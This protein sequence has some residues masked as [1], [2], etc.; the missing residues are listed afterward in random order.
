MRKLVLIIAI[1]L[2][3][4]SFSQ[5]DSVS[6]GAGYIHQAFYSFSNGIVKTSTSDWELAFGIGGFNIDIRTNEGHSVKLYL[7]PNG[8][9][10]DWNN[11]DTT[12][13][14]NWTPRHNDENDW[15]NTAFTTGGNHPDYGWGVY[16]STT[17]NVVGDSIYIMQTKAGNFKKLRI[18]GMYA[19]TAEFV[20]T[21]ADLDGSNQMTGK[22]KKTD[23]TGKNFAYYSVDN[24]TVLDLEPMAADWD[25]VFNKYGAVHPTGGYYN[26]TGIQTN[27]NR[28]S[29]EARGVDLNTVD[30]NTQ[31]FVDEIG[32][33][34]WDWKSF[35][36]GTFSYDIE[37]SLTYFVADTNNNVWQITMT[38]FD[39][40]VGKF[41]FNKKRVSGVSVE[42]INS[43]FNEVKL[44]PNP[45]TQNVT[46]SID[47]EQAQNNVELNIYSLTGQRVWSQ[48]INIV[49]QVNVNIPVSEWQKGIYIVRIGNNNAVVKQLIVQ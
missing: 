13:L 39:Y 11:I 6:I 37:D 43:G 8:D 7:Y 47:S 48:R 4:I 16:N 28:T 23:Y 18:D 30:W 14:Q 38:G 34:G 46:I 20:F 33:I 31:N 35:N 41:V 17:H 24:N 1:C 25:I 15:S 9:T 42:D 19:M 3:L 21:Y 5:A 22:V 10:A 27:K 26:V 12:G 2:P 49:D 44:Y 32:T 36:M 40:T 29:A 45:A